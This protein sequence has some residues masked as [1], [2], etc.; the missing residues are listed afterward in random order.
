M[1]SVCTFSF[2]NNSVL[3]PFYR[4][5]QG[6][7]PCREEACHGLL[8]PKWRAKDIRVQEE[9]LMGDWLH[10]CIQTCMH[11]FPRSA[12]WEDLGEALPS[13]SESSSYPDLSFWM[14]FSTQKNQCSWGKWLLPGLGQGKYKMS[15]QHFLPKHRK[16]WPKSN[17]D[18]SKRLIVSPPNIFNDLKNKE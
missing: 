10:I 9:A 14:P 5:E 7:R 8:K 2:L 6:R 12:H 1:G 15:L 11:T 18:V 3:E 17:G 4:S 13:N 16:K